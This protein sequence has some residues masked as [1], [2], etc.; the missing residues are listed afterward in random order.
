M[1]SESPVASGYQISPELATKVPI[2]MPIVIPLS[3][4][5]LGPCVVKNKPYDSPNGLICMAQVQHTGIDPPF[6][7]IATGFGR[8]NVV[9]TLQYWRRIEF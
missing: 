2:L 4:T 1:G 5:G 3:T 8:V 6:R 9:S 7:H